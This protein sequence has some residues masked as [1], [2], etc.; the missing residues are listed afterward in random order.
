MSDVLL[1]HG[2][3]HGA[4]CWDDVS[5]YLTESGH[6]PIAVDLPCDEQ[7]SGLT[8]YADAAIAALPPTSHDLI[9]VGH[10][11]GGLTATVVAGRVKTRRLVFVA[12]VIGLPGMSLADLATVDAD[13]DQHL[14]SGTLEFNDA[15]LFRFSREG[16]MRVLFHDCDPD[17]AEVAFVKLRFQRSLR[18]EVAEF[19]D[20]RAEEIV[21]V[22]CTDDRVINPSWGR[23][24]SRDRLGVEAL[25]LAGGHSPWLS[26]PAALARMLVG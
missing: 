5:S 4:W 24:V 12:G 10:S 13:R 17:S 9:V 3:C 21:S 11:L 14:G 8:Q 6:R 7:E 23:Q 26:Q 20:W 25:E 2:A 16:A 18:N 15:G 1:I 22:V 19:G